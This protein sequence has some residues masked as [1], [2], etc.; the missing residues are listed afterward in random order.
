MNTWYTIYIYRLI[1]EKRHAPL[2][3]GRKMSYQVLQKFI[4]KNKLIRINL[5]EEKKKYFL[6]S[7]LSFLEFP[8]KFCYAGKPL[9]A[10]HA[11]RQRL[12]LFI[13]LNIILVSGSSYRYPHLLDVV[14][15]GP[16]T[17]FQC[18]CV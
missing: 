8:G 6:I 16:K 4:L 14:H 3:R 5:L 7:I 12:T 13:V 10:Q 2:F 1:L 11:Q 9:L 17:A 15:S 18:F